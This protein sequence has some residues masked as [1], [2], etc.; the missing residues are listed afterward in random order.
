MP[1]ATTPD[2]EQLVSD[3]EDLLSGDA[4][5]LDVV[6]ESFTY[7][8]PGMPEDGLQG[9]DAYGEFLQSHRGAFPDLTVTVES[10]LADGEVTMQ[11]WTMV[12]T[13]E[14]EFNGLAPT[15]RVIEMK[16]MSK[17]TIADGKIQEVREYY[18]P[19]EFMGQL[20]VSE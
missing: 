14:G 17:T 8:G 12:G 10:G 3:Y 18:D 16:T 13:H 11:E 4:S 20:G 2:V 15:D 7:Y 6:S 5:K 19:Q 1:R 9:R